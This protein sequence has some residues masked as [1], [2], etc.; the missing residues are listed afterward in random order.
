M[1][2]EVI[3]LVNYYARNAFSRHVQTVCNEVLKKRAAPDATLLF[4]RAFGMLQE[5]ALNEAI[6]ELQAV[7]ARGDAHL[8]LP[9]K[10][11]LLHAHQQARAIDEEE[12]ARLRGEVDLEEQNAPER[13]R[14]TAALL[15][16]HLGDAPRARTLQER[17]WKRA[18]NLGP[19][20]P[21]SAEADAELRA[22]AD[23]A[24]CGMVYAGVKT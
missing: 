24:R 2:A 8:S 20:G 4:W 11:A 23:E 14:M 17:K 21:W 9:V 16:W 15:L 5:G 10:L 22:T 18:Q 7:E 12:V 13:A 1:S 19:W 3:A 6:K